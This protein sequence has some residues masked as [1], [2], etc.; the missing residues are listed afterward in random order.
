MF[1]GAVGYLKIGTS[2]QQNLLDT[3]SGEDAEVY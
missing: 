3:G 1:W 2:G